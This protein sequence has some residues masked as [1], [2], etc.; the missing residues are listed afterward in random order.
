MFV[1]AN[2]FYVFVACLAFGALVGVVFSFLEFF[3]SLIG[4]RW[5][6]IIADFFAFIICF[7][8]FEI[9]SFNMHFPSF[10]LYMVLGV[11][12]GIIAYKKSFQIILAKIVKK[13]YNKFTSRKGKGRNDTRRKPKSTTIRKNSYA[14]R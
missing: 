13:L 2:Q 12:L 7:V 14:R 3:S 11:F 4:K 10:R 5:V 1:T 9:Y 8:L 6:K